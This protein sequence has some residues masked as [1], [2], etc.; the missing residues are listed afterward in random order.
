MLSDFYIHTATIYNQ[1]VLVG[2]LNENIETRT[3]VAS[4]VQCRLVERSSDIE[5]FQGNISTHLKTL[6]YIDIP[7]GFNLKEWDYV[8]VNE[9]TQLYKIN[10]HHIAYDM[11]GPHHVEL[12]V[13]KHKPN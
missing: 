12:D 4:G 2:Q 10:D 11:N 6:I 9:V 1:G 3:V 7:V 13:Y 8:Y 5:L